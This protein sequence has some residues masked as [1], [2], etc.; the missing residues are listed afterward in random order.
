MVW[1]RGGRYPIVRGVLI[2][3][4]FCIPLAGSTHLAWDKHQGRIGLIVS[5]LSIITNLLKRLWLDER[6]NKLQDGEQ[7]KGRREE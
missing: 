3:K 1:D 7:E 2:P 4:E 6:R 5:S